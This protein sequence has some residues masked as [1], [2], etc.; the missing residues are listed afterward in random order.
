MSALCYRHL[1]GKNYL[2]P[3]WLGQQALA[4]RW[5]EELAN[6]TPAFLSIDQSY[7]A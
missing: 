1:F 6:Y 2:A 7:A 3:H 4:F 5:L